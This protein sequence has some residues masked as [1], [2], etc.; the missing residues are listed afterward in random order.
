MRTNVKKHDPTDGSGWT[1]EDFYPFDRYGNYIAEMNI[2]EVHEKVRTKKSPVQNINLEVVNTS[3]DPVIQFAPLWA[4]VR[5][6]IVVRKGISSRRT[7]ASTPIWN[8][9]STIWQEAIVSGEII[10]KI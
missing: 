10:L 1:E 8:N 4:F 9:N 5:N 3:L 2:P 6:E 7:S